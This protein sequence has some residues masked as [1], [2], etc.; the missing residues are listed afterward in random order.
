MKITWTENAL[1][2]TKEIFYFYK[3]KVTV[4]VANKVKRDIF[5]AVRN[6]KNHPLQGQIES[7]L[8]DK[9][10]EYRYLIAGQY[11]IIYKIIESEIFIIKV[12][13]CRRNPVIISIIEK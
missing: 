13:D 11:K 2:E 1:A 7:L 6:L 10:D 5:S 4:K 9:P 12:F 3:R 8:K